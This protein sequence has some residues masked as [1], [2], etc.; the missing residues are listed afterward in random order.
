MDRAS[1][2]PAVQWL[3]PLNIGV[4]MRLPRL[5]SAST[6]TDHVTTAMHAVMTS[7]SRATDSRLRGA[8]AG[9][10]P[11]AVWAA[12]FVIHVF[13]IAAPAAMRTVSTAV[14]AQIK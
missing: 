4:G 14:P 12:R 7:D 3:A 6:K 8:A 1:M 10:P 5:V 2:M 13:P 11:A 9:A